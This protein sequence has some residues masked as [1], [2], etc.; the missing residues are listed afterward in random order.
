[1]SFYGVNSIAYDLLESYLTQRQQVVEYY[2]CILYNT[3][4]LS[5]LTY[6]IISWG[7][8]IDKIYLLQKRAIRN[9]TKSVYNAH[10][11]LLII[12][13]FIRTYRS[14]LR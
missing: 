11:E 7:S 13:F 9:V 10:A 12:T 4:W 8:Q 3:V 14:R 5:H 2:D 6:C 1:M